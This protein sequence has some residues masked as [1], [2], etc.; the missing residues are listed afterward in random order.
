M[1][2]RSDSDSEDEMEGVEQDEV[3]SD[4]EIGEGDEDEEDD[5]KMKMDEDDMLCPMHYLSP[6][7]LCLL[8][9]HLCL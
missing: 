2:R 4:D 3:A 5:V 7:P 1:Q 8:R 9:R 6:P